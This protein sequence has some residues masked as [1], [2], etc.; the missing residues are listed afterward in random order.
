MIISELILILSGLLWKNA[1]RH[2]LCIL[3]RFLRKNKWDGIGGVY[4]V[5]LMS[6]KAEIEEET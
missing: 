4:L 6:L 5:S 2:L 1:C 3:L